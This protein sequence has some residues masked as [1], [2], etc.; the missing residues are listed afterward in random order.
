MREVSVVVRWGASVLEVRRLEL[1][2]SRSFADDRLKIE[3]RADGTWVHAGETVQPLASEAPMVVA[4]GDFTFELDARSDM[5]PVSRRRVDAAFLGACVLS[6]LVHGALL[7]GVILLRPAFSTEVDLSALATRMRT[8]QFAEPL[9]VDSSR[10]AEEGASAREEVPGAATTLTPKT[11][12]LAHGA[13]KSVAKPGIANGGDGRATRDSVDF[14]FVRLLRTA[15]AAEGDAADD[16]WAGVGRDLGGSWGTAA[17]EGDAMAGL[18]LQGIGSPAGGRGA[19][20]GLLDRGGLSA[21]PHCEGDQ[22][23]EPS[24]SITQDHAT[25]PPRIRLCGSPSD[26]MKKRA[27]C[28]NVSGRLPAAVIQ[29]IMRQRFGR[30]RGCYERSL[31][32]QPNLETRVTVRFVIGRD[33]GLQSADGSGDDRALTACVVKELYGISFPEPEGGAVHVTYP[34]AFSPG[35]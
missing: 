34:I 15:T 26:A 28:I 31:R 23:R 25:R 7:A 24:S 32:T 33:G 8:E 21:L 2:E 35:G 9:V 13:A 1:H 14:A 20:V 17:W 27:P 22:C 12:S 3:C 19:G 4:A 18:A 11:T 16:P 10:E 5:R 6:V 30:F 29:R